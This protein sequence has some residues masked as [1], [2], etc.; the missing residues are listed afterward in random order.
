[1]FLFVYSLAALSRGKVHDQNGCVLLSEPTKNAAP[2]TS[3]SAAAPTPAASCTRPPHF[4]ERPPAMRSAKPRNPTADAASADTVM[5]VPTAIAKVENTPAH[6][7][8]WL[9]AKKKTR[10]APVQ[11]R[12]PTAKAMANA[13]FQDHS[14]CS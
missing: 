14:P 3:T 13:R 1:M 7:S 11:G 4:D 12:M 10:I 6:Q 9:M 5:A 8:P 2:M